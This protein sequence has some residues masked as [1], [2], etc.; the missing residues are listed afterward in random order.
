VVLQS[1]ENGFY[2]V[3][4]V[5]SVVVINDILSAVWGK[6]IK[7]P[8]LF[9]AL[10]PNKSLA[11]YIGGSACAVWAGFIIWFVLP[12]FTATQVLIAALLVS[13]AGSAGDLFA[14]RIKR[15]NGVKDFGT[16]LLTMGGILD[17]LDS[18]L[19]AGWAFFLYLKFVVSL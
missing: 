6:L 2:Y 16:V 10:S 8:R 15:Q 1:V 13:V 3:L 14:S 11:G 9:P 4:W 7:S 12:D 18:L 19:S 17:R 5:I